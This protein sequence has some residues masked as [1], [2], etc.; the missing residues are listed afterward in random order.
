VSSDP[1]KAKD[2]LNKDCKV[3]DDEVKRKKRGYKRNFEFTG[4]T[5][6]PMMPYFR[7]Y[8]DGYGGQSSMD[9]MSFEGE[10]GFLSLLAQL[11]L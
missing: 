9:D 2:K 3:C 6:G 5:K 7:L 8:M 1:G 10:M 11:G 4:L